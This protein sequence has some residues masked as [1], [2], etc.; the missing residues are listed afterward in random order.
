MLLITQLMQM[1]IP[2]TLIRDVLL[3]ADWRVVDGRL[4]VKGA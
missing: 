2:L 4:W 3:G 1:Q